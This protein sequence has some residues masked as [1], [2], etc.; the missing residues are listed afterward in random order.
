MIKRWKVSLLFKLVQ[1]KRDF[2]VNI[3][4]KERESKGHCRLPLEVNI[5][6]FVAE[7]NRHL[8]TGAKLSYKKNHY[9]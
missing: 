8:S 2:G 6:D 1:L 5:F 3:M 7:N 4:Y 9:G